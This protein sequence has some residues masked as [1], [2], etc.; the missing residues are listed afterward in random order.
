MTQIQD[1]MTEHPVTVGK[2]TSLA[3]A[4]RVMRDADIGDVL[5]VDDGE[6]SG[7]LTDRDLVVRAMAE[8]KDP[9]DTTVQSVC[10]TPPVTPVPSVCTLSASSM[11]SC[12]A[13]F[14]HPDGPACAYRGVEEL[15]LHGFLP[16]RLTPGPGLW[17]SGDRFRCRYW[18]GQGA[19]LRVG[20]GPRR[21]GRLGVGPRLW[22]CGRYGVGSARSG[23]GAGDGAWLGPGAGPRC[24]S[25][26]G[27][28]GIVGRCT[29]GDHLGSWMP[30]SGPGPAAPES[31][32]W[33]RP[34]YFTTTGARGEAVVPVLDPVRAPAAVSVPE[35]GGRRGTGAQAVAPGTGWDPAGRDGSA[36]RCSCGS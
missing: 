35:S 6:L 24:R 25:R 15:Q 31:G 26:T 5:V 8:D 12:S 21:G 3:E 19:G 33:G 22:R 11:R 16:W 29:H 23:N 13:S 17:E 14:D 32:F 10:S 7:I 2:L 27:R 36:A 4:A 20:L 1:V 9:A 30:R 18:S 34:G 28:H